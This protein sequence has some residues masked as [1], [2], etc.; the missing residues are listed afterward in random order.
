MRIKL[1]THT[2][3]DGVGCAILMKN[4]YRNGEIDIEYCDYGNVNDKIEKFLNSNEDFN[5]DKV[6]ITDISVDESIS[7]WIQT[8]IE[9]NETYNKFIL[10]DHHKTAEW[11]NRFDWAKVEE[12]SKYLERK[13]SG[14]QMLHEWFI[15][16][17]SE[18]IKNNWFNSKEFISMVNNYDTWYWKEVGDI[19]PKQLNDLLYIYGRDKFIDKILY[20]L[21]N[22]LLHFNP[23]DDLLLKLRQ[24][25]ID[26]YIEKKN[27]SIIK[28]ELKGLSVGAVFA[29]NYISEVGNILCELNKD[30]DLIALI[31]MDYSISYRTIKD[32]IDVSE[33]AKIFDGGGHKKASGSQIDIYMKNTIIEE[34]FYK[35]Y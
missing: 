8:K 28:I 9:L 4:V 35:A 13:T 25:D 26:R 16:N 11:L 12:N 32:H 31:N 33:F 34:L 3:L 27:K 6:F 17:N 1:F 19:K 29:E 24:E 22:C 10:L 18:Y 7:N 5:F 2:D 30:L 23:T 20:E 21:D 15:S 14:T